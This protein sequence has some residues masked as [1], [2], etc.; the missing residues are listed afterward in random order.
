MNDTIATSVRWFT[1]LP[2]FPFAPMI[3]FWAGRE[4]GFSVSE[5]DAK[6]WIG[7]LSPRPVFLMQG[8]ADKVISSN[9]GE[10][11]YQAAGQPKEL[12]FDPALG[13]AKFFAERRAEYE[14]RVLGF[15]DRY[16]KP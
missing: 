5:I 7:R 15:W 6:K 13:H 10:L 1:G 4:G 14:R 9:S 11:L 3:A 16:L 8:G 12:W 2:P